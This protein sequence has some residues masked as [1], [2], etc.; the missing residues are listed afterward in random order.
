[1]TA[2]A[3][4]AGLEAPRN[5]DRP[6]GIGRSTPVSSSRLRRGC[7]EPRD[8]YDFVPAVVNMRRPMCAELYHP[9]GESAENYRLTKR[10]LQ[11]K[12]IVVFHSREPLAI[13]PP[14]GPMYQRS[15]LKE[16]WY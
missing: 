4:R 6:S 3:M 9:G 13:L 1:M 11:A 14:R 15:I 8:P 5:A 2:R 10:R 12:G 16:R 7:A